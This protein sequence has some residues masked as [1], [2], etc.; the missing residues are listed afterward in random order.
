MKNKQF[1]SFVSQ[2]KWELF[3]K[4]NFISSGTFLPSQYIAFLPY[5]HPPNWLIFHLLSAW[6]YIYIFLCAIFLSSYIVKK[7]NNKITLSQV[8]IYLFLIHS[9]NTRIRCEICSK[10]TL[11][12][13]KL[14][15]VCA[16]DYIFILGRKKIIFRNK[17]VQHG[18]KIWNPRKLIPEPLVTRKL[19]PKGTPG[20][21]YNNIAQLMT[22]ATVV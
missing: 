13:K 21:L 9:R 5:K 6:S 19:I 10:L 7:V 18:L 12:N 17:C 3:L 20:F 14:G 2:A 22:H 4:I 11:Y 15:C 8:N 1:Y 16:M